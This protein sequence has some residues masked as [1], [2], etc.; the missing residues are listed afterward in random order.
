M[1]ETRLI[2][3]FIVSTMTCNILCRDC[4]DRFKYHTPNHPDFRCTDCRADWKADEP[5]R[6]KKAKENWMS[7]NAQRFTCSM[8]DVHCALKSDWR[9][10]C[11][12]NRHQ[13]NKQI[14]V[15]CAETGR[16]PKF[17]KQTKVGTFNKQKKSEKCKFSCSDN[18]KWER[19]VQSKK[20]NS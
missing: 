19:H 6:K 9:H 5:E 17:N 12:S 7:R 16:T 11:M 18:W 15:L 4:G 8:C 1:G 10:H 3:S 14:V 13:V 20:H 2:S